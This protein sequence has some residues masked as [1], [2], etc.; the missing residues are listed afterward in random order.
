M[1]HFRISDEGEVEFDIFGE[2]TEHALFELAY[3]LLNEALLNAPTDEAGNLTT[4]GQA[5]ISDV[6]AKERNRI[7]PKKVKEPSTER[8]RAMKKIMRAPTRIIDRV[9]R[10]SATETLQRLPVKRKPN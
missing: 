8:G 7:R 10:E 2:V 3:P 6:V 1:V 9:I 4:E 5:V